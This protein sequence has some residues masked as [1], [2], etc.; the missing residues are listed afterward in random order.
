MEVL[1]LLRPLK[2]NSHKTKL[3]AEFFADINWWLKYIVTFNCV[4]LLVPTKTD[5]ALYTDASNEGAGMLWEYDWAYL[6]WK[7][8]A[9]FIHEEHIN[10][11]ETFTVVAA[12]FR[13]APVWANCNIIVHTD[14]ISTRAA[15][16]KGVCRNPVLMQFLRQ[17]FWLSVTFNF[18][19]KAVHIPGKCNVEADSL[20]RLGSYGH[21]R[22]WHQIITCG[23]PL[24]M[25]RFV[26]MSIHHMSYKSLSYVCSQIQRWYKNWTKQLPFTDQEPLRNQQRNHTLLT[27]DPT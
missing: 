2:Q 4:K 15:I 26:F 17:V 7:I 22:H 6:N 11:K 27:W 16:N 5:V 19:L 14:N 10:I 3:T 9:P 18:S 13:W 24:D 1:D 20:S 23:A 12:I 25:S 8:D 21:C